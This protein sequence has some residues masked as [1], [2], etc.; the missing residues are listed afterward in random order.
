[1]REVFAAIE[2]RQAELLDELNIRW[3]DSGL[4]VARGMALHL[5]ERAWSGAAER[6]I[7]VGKKTAADLYVHC[8]AKALQ[9]SG[10]TVPEGSLP[11]S[12]IMKKLVDET[13]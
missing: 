5:F 13:Q 2:R 8:L 11:E 9:A 6:G 12:D 3:A 4:R 10:V 1:M 7:P